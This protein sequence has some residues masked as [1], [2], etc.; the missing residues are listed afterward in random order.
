MQSMKIENIEIPMTKELQEFFAYRYQN[1]T[2]KLVDEFLVYLNTKKEAYEVNK[3]LQEVKEGK[4]N[5]IG[6]LF[7]DL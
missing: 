7:D 5:D 1:Q 2:A 4:T 3:A 6:K